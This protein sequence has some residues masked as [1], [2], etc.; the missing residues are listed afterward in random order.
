VTWILATTVFLVDHS[1]L[2]SRHVLLL[3]PPLALGASANVLL[4]P[5]LLSGREGKGITFVLF[6]LLLVFAGLSLNT[7]QRRFPV[8][9]VYAE[10]DWEAIEL[11]QEH[12]QPLDFVVSDEQ[13]QVFRAGRH[14]PPELCDT[15]NIR[16]KSGYLTDEEAIKASKDAR[17][18][19]LW[20]SR[21]ARLSLYTN[22]V[23]ANYRLVRTW[24]EPSYRFFVKER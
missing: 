23:E 15:S 2:F 7:H 4:I 14:V 5:M 21:L 3:L 12:T 20:T 17:V 18:I 24:D 11:I 8:L 22:W 6:I 13:M 9:S 19:I 16:I 10:R 1:P